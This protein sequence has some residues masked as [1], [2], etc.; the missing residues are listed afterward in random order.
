MAQNY[1]SANTRRLSNAVLML[2]QRRR[3]WTWWTNLNRVFDKHFLLLW[4]KVKQMDH[5]YIF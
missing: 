3:R 2:G 4:Q 5:Y 1:Y